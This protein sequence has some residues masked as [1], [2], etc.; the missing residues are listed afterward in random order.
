M[1]TLETDRNTGEILSP[2]TFYL[3]CKGFFFSKEK[4]QSLNYSLFLK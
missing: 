3:M 2:L 4:L 1:L